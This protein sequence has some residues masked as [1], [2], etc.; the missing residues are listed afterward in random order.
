MAYFDGAGRGRE[1]GGEKKGE[2]D[3]EK[4]WKDRGRDLPDQCQRRNATT[5]GPRH[6]LRSVTPNKH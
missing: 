2:G 1:S 5:R 4:G 6:F 3:G